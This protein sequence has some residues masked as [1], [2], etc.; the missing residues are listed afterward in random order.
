MVFAWTETTCETYGTG[1]LT[2]H[3]FCDKKEIPED[4]R[5][6]TSS[7]LLQSFVASMAGSY[8]GA[9]ISNYICGIRAWHIL[10][11]VR[12]RL[13]DNEMNTLLQAAARLAPE[14]S[15]RKKRRPYTTDFIAKLRSHLD[16]HNPLD[17]AV[18]A[19]LATCFYATARVGEF[20]VHRSSPYR[21]QPF[22][23]Y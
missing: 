23:P 3:V 7:I 11:G 16:L 14:S 8:S 17:A 15:R 6:P 2:Y 22:T 19:C 12:W 13:N 18:F 20:T 10:H 21:L 4:Q 1:L 5:A 9:A